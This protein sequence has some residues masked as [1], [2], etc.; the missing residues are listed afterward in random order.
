M[1]I[2]LFAGMSECDRQTPK[3]YVLSCIGTIT[4]SGDG[5]TSTYFSRQKCLDKS[6]KELFL[7]L[8]LE[9]ESE[10]YFECYRGY[11][12]GNIDRVCF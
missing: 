8:P 9:P 10:S 12:Y 6:M 2:M 4:P 3:I 11:F 1:A 5:R 7:K